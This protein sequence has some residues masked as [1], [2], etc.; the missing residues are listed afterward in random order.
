MAVLHGDK[1][2]PLTS[3]SIIAIIVMSSNKA[4][5]VGRASNTSMVPCST[6]QLL[7][8]DHSH[9]ARP[10]ATLALSL[11]IVRANQLLGPSFGILK[12]GFSLPKP[13]RML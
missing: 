3:T 12:Y 4:L 2:L 6:L 7:L 1:Y 13:W 8:R 11:A 10:K 5:P 9:A